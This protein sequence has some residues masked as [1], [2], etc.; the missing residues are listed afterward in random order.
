MGA[1]PQ[2]RRPDSHGHR[3]SS[4]GGGLIVTDF[5]SAELGTLSQYVATLREAQQQLAALPSSLSGNDTMLGNDKLNDAAEQF[6]H[7]WEYGAKQLSQS[8][9]A[10]TDAVHDVHGAY[11]AADGAVH[12]AVSSLQQPLSD[13]GQAAGQLNGPHKS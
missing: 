13:I 10:T 1:N 4:T 9:S 3:Q 5:F 2:I 11:T 12:D 6:Q 7:S 8:V